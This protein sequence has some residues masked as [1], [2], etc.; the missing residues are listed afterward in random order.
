MLHE[1]GALFARR[2][3]G[4]GPPLLFFDLLHRC[5][6]RHRLAVGVLVEIGAALL[7]EP[8]QLLGQIRYLRQ[9]L[10]SL[11]QI[12]R[13]LEL[14]VADLH[15]IGDAV[16]RQVVRVKRRQRRGRHLHAREII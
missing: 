3:H 5:V 4:E 12:I 8:F 6:V 10:V 14:H 9:G 15:P 11:R 2:S 1:L 13:D 16:F 7:V